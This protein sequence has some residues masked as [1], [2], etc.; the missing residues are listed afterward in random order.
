MKIPKNTAK[1]EK[2][3]EFYINGPAYLRVS[4][5]TQKDYYRNLY[6]AAGTVVAS[7]RK[8]GNVRICDLTV[9]MLNVG[10]EKWVANNGIRQANYIKSC[11]SI[12][13]RHGMKYDIMTHNPVSLVETLP[14]K[15]RKVRWTREQ[16]KT[17]LDVAYS[18]YEYFNLG[19]VVHMAYD[20]GQRV[21]DMRMLTWAS[22]DLDSCQIDLTQS[23][24]NA[25]VHL[26][27]SKGLC[28]ILHNQKD[29]LGFQE[30]VAPKVS[31]DRGIVRP[32]LI[33]E[34]SPNINKILDEANL[35]KHLTAMDLRRTCVTEM[36]AAGV[37]TV[38]MMNVTGHRNP[39]S[40]KPY[41]VNT[42][43]GAAKAL[44]ARGND[45]EYS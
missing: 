39:A 2:L 28:R 25:D 18:K 27:I 24:R 17:F 10:Y 9:G 13:W 6:I 34:I 40:L 19:L 31:L 16:I 23:K 43:E 4:G 33:N 37:D 45:D 3:I 44:S 26:P 5:T 30:Y 15:Q 1:M 42:V 41:L 38:S 22:L 21:G 8:L 12:A 14:T 29:Q 35:P 7:N 36:S 11:L 32:Y 20:W